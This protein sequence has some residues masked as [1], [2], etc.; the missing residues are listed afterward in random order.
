M[1]DPNKKRLGKVAQ[2]FNVS[3]EKIVDLL[4]KKNYSIENN[5]NT[6][7]DEDMYEILVKEYSSERKVKEN[8][9]KKHI[10]V[11]KNQEPIVVSKPAV[12]EQEDVEE[13][14]VF[15]KDN[16]IDLGRSVIEGPKILGKIDLNAPKTSAKKASDNHASKP[17]PKPIETSA[18]PSAEANYVEESAS[19]DSVKLEEAKKQ[20]QIGR[21]SCRERV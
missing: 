6:K 12:V 14:E 4:N 21:A 20:V 3:T 5:P 17:S 19:T 16:T 10:E 15:I 7:L 18:T 9:Q 2:E 11:L 8:A 1:A 13:R